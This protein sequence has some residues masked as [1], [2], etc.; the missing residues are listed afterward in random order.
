MNPLRRR[1]APPQVV[2]P[3]RIVVQEAS[4]YEFFLNDIC[5]HCGE[6]FGD[7]LAKDPHPSAKNFPS[8]EGFAYGKPGL[9]T[10]DFS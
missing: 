8:C 1:S 5:K 4:K 6:E 7:H 3:L 9:G 10:G 2:S